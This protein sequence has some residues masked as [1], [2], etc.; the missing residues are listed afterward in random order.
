MIAERRVVDN[1]V[2]L[3]GLDELYRGAMKRHEQKELLLC[4][5]EIAAKLAVKP[6]NVPIEGYYYESEELTEY[7]RLVRA[8]QRVPKSRESEL[9]SAAS[10]SRLKQ[11]VTSP[12]FGTPLEQGYLLPAGKD[13]L[14]VALEQTSPKWEIGA[15]TEAAYQCAVGGDD[16]SLVGLAALARD[17]VVLCALRE[18]VVLYAAVMVGGAAAVPYEYVWNVDD[19]VEARAKKF[20]ETFNHLFHERL[21]EPIAD[22]ANGFW[23]AC[24]EWKCL[25]RCVRIGFNDAVHPP[26]Q[27]H[28]AIDRNEQRKLVV[29]DFWDDE[30]WTTERY[31]K[32][33][34]RPM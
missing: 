34:S 11:V 14:A 12:I 33:F 15:L 7:F 32:K 3:L 21:P 10:F 24:N 4:A 26:K 23:I 13:P 1:R 19:V 17:P 22:N 9:Q 29:K 25:G 16:F 27:Y 30:V 20:V 2:F 8:L 6:A 31:S 18:S 5:R 28:W